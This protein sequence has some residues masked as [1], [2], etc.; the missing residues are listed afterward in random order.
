MAE[1]LAKGFISAGQDQEVID[2][3]EA[4]GLPLAING[5]EVLVDN[6]KRNESVLNRI[7]G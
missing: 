7:L 6:L 3:A 5:P 2:G 1:R 4:A